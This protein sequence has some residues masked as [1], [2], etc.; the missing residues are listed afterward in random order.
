MLL[1]TFFIVSSRMQ[2]NERGGHRNS[3]FRR[4]AGSIHLRRPPN[5]EEFMLQRNTGAAAV[6]PLLT[7]KHG[8][9]FVFQRHRPVRNDIAPV[10]YGIVQ[11][12]GGRPRRFRIEGVMTNSP[13]RGTGF[14]PPTR[15]AHTLLHGAALPQLVALLTL[16]TCTAA[17]LM[18]VT[19]SVGSAGKRN[20]IPVS[21]NVQSRLL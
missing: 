12:W 11:A 2:L 10:L 3:E 16:V 19:W 1:M 21:S 17:V 15:S 5:L 13:F 14:T 8:I 9:A 6:N 18:A 20:A 7:K 4:K